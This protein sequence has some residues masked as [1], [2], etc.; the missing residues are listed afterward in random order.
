MPVVTPV[1]WG[2]TCNGE[3]KEIQAERYNLAICLLSSSSHSQN[4]ASIDQQREQE[5]DSGSGSAAAW[6]ENN[7][8]GR[9]IE[10][11]A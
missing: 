2:L 5:H 1:S 7:L 11:L 8:L 9:S 4:K 3:T 6:Y 10:H